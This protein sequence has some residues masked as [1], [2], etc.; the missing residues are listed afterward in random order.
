MRQ[1]Y[2]IPEG[3]LFQLN[4]KLEKLNK[5]AVKLGMQPITLTELSKDFVPNFKSCP[6]CGS[7]MSFL[8]VSV[9][10]TSTWHQYNA[11]VAAGKK[12]VIEFGTCGKKYTWEGR[13]MRTGGCGFEGKPNFDIFLII[14][15]TGEAPKINGW[16]F[17]ATLQHTDGQTIFRRVP[18][19][20]TEIIEE[21]IRK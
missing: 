5:K 6:R 7:K 10:Q 12:D 4:K 2:R 14:E 1:E 21:S 3:N 8:P 15:V 18:G 16:E 9:H 11:D 20:G 17:A 13:P 19:F